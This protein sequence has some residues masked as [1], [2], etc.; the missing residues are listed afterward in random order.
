MHKGERPPLSDEAKSELSKCGIELPEEGVR[1]S[2]EERKIIKKCLKDAGI[3]KP[4]KH[5]KRHKR[6]NK[7]GEA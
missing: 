5:R 7:D 1:P 6:P 4:K 2:R 3:E